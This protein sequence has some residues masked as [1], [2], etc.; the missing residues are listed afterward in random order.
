[1]DLG[2]LLD[3]ISTGVVPPSTKTTE[4]TLVSFL[5]RGPNNQSKV[6]GNRDKL[7]DVLF[8]GIKVKFTLEVLQ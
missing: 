6:Y 5:L 3:G 7:L 1:M 8:V 4:I 2:P